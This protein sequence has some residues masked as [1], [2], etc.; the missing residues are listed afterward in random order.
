MNTQDQHLETLFNKVDFNP[1]KLRSIDSK[2]EDK[3]LVEENGPSD[4]DTLMD[5]SSN[6]LLGAGS[7]DGVQSLTPIEKITSYSSSTHE[8]IYIKNS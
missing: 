2:N 5:R 8:R 3:L 7:L 6:L 1:E 4:D